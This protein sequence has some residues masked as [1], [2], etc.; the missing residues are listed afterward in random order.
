VITRYTFIQIRVDIGARG[1]ELQIGSS[2]EGE[3]GGEGRALG[4]YREVLM[5]NMNRE[6]EY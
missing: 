5:N 3:G 1:D 2:G 6:E 4:E